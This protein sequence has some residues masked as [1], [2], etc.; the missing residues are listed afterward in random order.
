MPQI[1]YVNNGVRIGGSKTDVAIVHKL[2]DLPG[3]RALDTT[4]FTPEIIESGHVII[5]E[6]ATDIYKP[7]PVL[8]D[9]TAYDVLPSGHEY[10][11]VLDGSIATAKPAAAI[12]VVGT[13][14]DL[15]C[16]YPVTD[17]MKTAFKGAQGVNI[18]WIHDNTATV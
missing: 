15:A 3:G 12:L 7:M 1:N 16:P 5:R 6:I 14:N 11:G 8:A 9:G 10:A 4:G 13:V 17:A 2:A 18:A